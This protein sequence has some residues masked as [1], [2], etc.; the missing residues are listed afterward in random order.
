MLLEAPG[1]LNTVTFK[2]CQ[3]NDLLHLLIL[4]TALAAIE[5]CRMPAAGVLTVKALAHVLTVKALAHV[6]TVKALAHVLTVKALAHVLTVKA[7]AHVLTVKAL[8]HVLAILLPRRNYIDVL[9]VRWKL[10]Y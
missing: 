3:Y 5:Y 4:F 9:F 1:S 2:S 10:R 6:L 7:L 8:A